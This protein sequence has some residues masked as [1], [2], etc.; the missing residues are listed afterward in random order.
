MI[1]R[2]MDECLSKY[3]PS[4]S[5]TSCST[6]PLMSL[7][8]LPLVCPSNCGCGSFTRNNGNESF[9][10]IIT[11]DG[12]FVL[13]LL[14]HSRMRL[15]KLLMVRVSAERK[16]ERCV[17]PS[18][19]LMVLANAKMFSR[20]SVVVLQRDFHFHV[21]ASCLPCK[22]ANRAALVLPRFRCL[23]NSAMPPVKRNSAL[24]RC[25]RRSSVIF[26]P[27]FRKAYSRRRVASVS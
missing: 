23:T 15:A 9:A 1:R 16:P 7:L 18:T 19:V 2:A 3:S 17:P 12:D 14:Q 22:L 13:L 27:L 20:V 8:S 6:S 26:R 21:A 25:A 11:G 4:F 24:F 5:F 10:H